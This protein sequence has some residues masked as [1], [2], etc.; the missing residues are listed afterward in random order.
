MDKN[1]ECLCG[2]GINYV[3]CC[4]PFHQ[5]NKYP[6]T[7][8]VLMRTRFTAYALKNADYLLNTW[9]ETNPPEVIDFSKEDVEWTRLEIVKTKKGSEK[10]SKGV[11]DFKA[12][13]LQDDEE[14]VMHEISRFKKTANRWS[15]LDGVVKSVSKA[16]LQTNQGKNAL[17]SC[18]S[19]KK[20]KR[21]CGK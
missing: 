13:Y 11:V 15:Y 6:N 12:Y 9:D 5:Y 3:L 19:G 17:C 10:D 14:F 2:S 21:C 7:A 20:F 16:G 1:S 18:G 8:E 4:Q